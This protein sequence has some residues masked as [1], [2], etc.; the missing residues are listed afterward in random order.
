MRSRD[1][2]SAHGR[3]YEVT[4]R[5]E[6]VDLD[7]ASVDV[8]VAAVEVFNGR[9]VRWEELGVEESLDDGALSNSSG[10][11]DDQTIAMFVFH[12]HP[13][14][15]HIAEISRFNCPGKMEAPPVF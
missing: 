11:K 5:I 10:S 14:S 7:R 3:K 2:Q 13:D 4:S 1:G 15:D 9:L 12:R 8:E 6:D